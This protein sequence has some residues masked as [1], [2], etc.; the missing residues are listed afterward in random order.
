VK[1]VRITPIPPYVDGYRKSDCDEIPLGKSNFFC[2][3]QVAWF[4]PSGKTCYVRVDDTSLDIFRRKGR[5]WICWG[6]GSTQKW[7][8][9][10]MQHGRNFKR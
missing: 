6:S 10:I 7:K 3:G 2:D 8:I 5:Y 1:T 4:S 9:G